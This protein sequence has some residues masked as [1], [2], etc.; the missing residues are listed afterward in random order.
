[1]NDFYANEYNIEAT[2]KEDD[3]NANQLHDTVG[4]DDKENVLQSK[5][6]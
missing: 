2:G 5:P 6:F 3:A 4:A 1:M